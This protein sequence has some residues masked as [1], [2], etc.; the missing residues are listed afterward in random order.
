[1]IDALSTEGIEELTDPR[2]YT[3]VAETIA[4]RTIDRTRGGSNGSEG[5]GNGSRDGGS[6]SN[7]SGDG[8]R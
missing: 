3:G 5:D 7:E 1:V 4:E 6:A 8:R 2:E